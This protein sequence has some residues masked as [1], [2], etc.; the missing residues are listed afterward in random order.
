LEDR[1]MK[2]VANRFAWFFV[3]G[4]IVSTSGCAESDAPVVAGEGAAVSDS[5][6]PEVPKIA[7]AGAAVA[8]PPAPAELQLESIDAGAAGPAHKFGNYYLMGQPTEAELADWKSKGVRTII[9]L[10]TPGEIDWDEKAAAE[11]Q[12][13]KFVSIPFRGAD[14]LGDAQIEAALEALKEGKDGPVILHCGSSNRVGA[15]W[16]AHR[17]RH[18]G[19]SPEAALAEAK[20]VGLRNTSLADVVTAYCEATPG[21]AG[22]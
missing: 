11:A 3:L 6:S 4:L 15:I 1:E 10:R 7:D 18:D 22:K 21:S 12:G 2:C 19:L 20:Q 9:S 8:E 5:E 13:M 17:I 16:Y 14:S